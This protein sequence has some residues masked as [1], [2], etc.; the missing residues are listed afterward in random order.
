MD[1]FSITARPRP[2]H[3]RRPTERR[4][5]HHSVLNMIGPRADAR[6]RAVLRDGC[7]RGRPN[8]TPSKRTV[9]PSIWLRTHFF[10]ALRSRA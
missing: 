10:T 2:A 7:F 5:I 8:V 3:G 4:P 1:Q 9:T 6:S